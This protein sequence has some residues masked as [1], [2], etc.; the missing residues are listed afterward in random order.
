[1]SDEEGENIL[2]RIGDL[3]NDNEEEGSDEESED[4]EIDLQKLIGGMDGDD[5]D[6]EGSEEEAVG[7]GDGDPVEEKGEED[8]EVQA[9][10]DVG[11]EDGE[12]EVGKGEQESGEGKLPSTDKHNTA[13][14]Q[15]EKEQQE[16]SV[17]KARKGKTY[18]FTEVSSGKAKD[19]RRYSQSN[20]KASLDE[21]QI[22][23]PL[24]KDS[25]VSEFLIDPTNIQKSLEGIRG[26]LDK[27]VD[28]IRINQ[29]R[30]TNQAP[31]AKY[32][33]TA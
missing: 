5:K 15:P 7:G 27:K 23:K 21:I 33:S 19:E 2:N 9:E 12:S 14:V 10:D 11:E 29:V 4:G 17:E 25:N 20:L 8:E 24:I 16:N 18:A 6:G 1:M 30:V 31:R 3:I 13:V 32:T 28:G 26:S 22:G